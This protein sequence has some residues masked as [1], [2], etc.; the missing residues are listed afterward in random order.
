MKIICIGRNYVDHIK[1]LNSAMPSAPVFFLKPDTALLTRNRP[2]YYPSFSKEIHH[3]IELVLKISKVGKAIQPKFASSYFDEIGIGFDLTARDLQ[4]EAKKKGLP[5]ALS[6]GFDQSAPISRFVPKST[7]PGMK[8]ISF[9]LKKNGETVQTGNSGLMI[10]P[11]DAMI[12]YVSQYMTLRTGDLLFTGTP[13]GVGPIKIGDVLE[14]YLEG[15][16]M[17]RCAIK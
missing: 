17:L 4:D 6:K 3:E 10:Y 1:E 8:N 13:A 15:E 14:G 2:F 16:Q 7:F 9:S 5:W 12:S 11:F